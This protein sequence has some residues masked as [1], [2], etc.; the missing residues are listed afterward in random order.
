MSYATDTTGHEAVTRLFD[1]AQNGEIDNVEF[2]Q[3]D[4]LV[5]QRFAQAYDA[6]LDEARTESIS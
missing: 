5:Y 6:P 1:L 3:L 2:A 4:S